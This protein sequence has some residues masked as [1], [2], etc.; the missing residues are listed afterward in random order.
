MTARRQLRALIAVATKLL[1]RGHDN[2]HFECLTETR[3]D[4]CD[5]L[6]ESGVGHV[7]VCSCRRCDL[8]IRRDY[9]VCVCAGCDAAACGLHE[10]QPEPATEDA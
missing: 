1:D 5:G 10:G 6:N 8:A 2:P 4:P 7:C 3:A 9:D